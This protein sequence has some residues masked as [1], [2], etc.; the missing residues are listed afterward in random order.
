[1]E[2]QPRQ[3]QHASS[4]SLLA[5]YLLLPN[6]ESSLSVS[7]L[8]RE[9]LELLDRLCLGHCE[10][11]FHVRFGVLVA[12]LKVHQLKFLTI[13]ASYLHRSWYHLVEMRGSR[14]GLCASAPHFL[15]RIVHIL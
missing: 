1:M 7:V 11:E 4:I 2:L 14:S 5:S 10:A 8:L 6:G 9:S 3:S 15:R 12:G 13:L